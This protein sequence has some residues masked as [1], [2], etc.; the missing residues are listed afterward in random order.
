MSIL[1]YNKLVYGITFYTYEMFIFGGFC[2][3]FGLGW[4]DYVIYVVCG[5][6]V[7][8]SSYLLCGYYSIQMLELSC[9]RLAIITYFIL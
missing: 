1:Y 6:Y 2:L 3:G 9:I 8:T 7:Y 5:V 4:V